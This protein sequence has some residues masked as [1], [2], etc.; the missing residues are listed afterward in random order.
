VQT[1]L[2]L[3]LPGALRV[4]TLAIIP[5]NRLLHGL[6]AIR[7]AISA[8]T[9]YLAFAGRVRASILARHRCL[10]VILLWHLLLLEP[11]AR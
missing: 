3:C 7:A 1:C 8:F 2:L 9:I 4:F 10:F 5:L 6:L 11:I